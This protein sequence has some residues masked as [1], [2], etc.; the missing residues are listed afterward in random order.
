MVGSGSLEVFATP[1]MVALMERAACEAINDALGEGQTTVGVYVSVD[2]LAATP[3][4]GQ[5]SAEATVDSVDGRKIEYTVTA[6]DSAGQIGI[7]THT[8]V[9]IDV[10]RFMKKANDRLKA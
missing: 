6:S 8:R 1:M 5:V 7:G 9:I 3:L 4:G 10:E 2:H